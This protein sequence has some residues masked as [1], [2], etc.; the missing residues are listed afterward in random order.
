MIYEIDKV[1]ILG[2]MTIKEAANEL[3]VIVDKQQSSIDFRFNG[4]ECTVHVGGDPNILIEQYNEAIKPR[5]A[6]SSIKVKP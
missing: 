5:K 2:G 1:S 4:V 3:Q 6:W